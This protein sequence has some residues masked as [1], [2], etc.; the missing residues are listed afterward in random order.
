MDAFD[1][2]RKV[3]RRHIYIQYVLLG[4]LTIDNRAEMVKIILEDYNGRSLSILLGKITVRNHLR[5]W[6][7]F[8]LTVL[9]NI[10]IA[11]SLRNEDHIPM[12]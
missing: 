5:Q 2:F 12:I 11:V 1:Y 3:R 6:G 10:L 4:Y 7:K 9:G 8:T